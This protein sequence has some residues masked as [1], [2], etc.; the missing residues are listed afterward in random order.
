MR[1]AIK[2]F[3]SIILIVST[4]VYSDDST[5]FYTEKN[6]EG[7]NTCLYSGQKID[8]YAEFKKSL[9][10]ESDPKI[11]DNDSVQSIMIPSGMMAKIYKNDNFSPP[12]FTLIESANV[13][14]LKRLGINREISSIKVSENKNLNC[15]RV[16]TI[17]SAHKINLSDAFG[18]Y[19]HD[20]RLVNRQIILILN[21]KYSLKIEGYSINLSKGPSINV[22]ENEIIFSD[23]NELNQFN[24]EYKKNANELAFIIQLSDDFVQYQYIQTEKKQLVDISP[25][26]SFKWLKEKQINPELTIENYN[27]YNIPVIINRAILTAD[28]GRKNSEKRDLSQ[29][30]K[31]IC[32]FTPFLNIYNYIT[33]GTCQQ[34]DGIIFNALDYFSNNTK[35]KTLHIAG[36]SRPLK[37]IT[38]SKI[39][40]NN[41]SDG[42]YENYLMLSYIDSTNHHQSLSLPAVAKT[43][44]TSIYRLI[45]SRPNRQGRPPC[46]D[47]TLDI[48]TDFTLLFGNDLSTW[49]SEYFS[50]IID[51]IIKTGS[52]GAVVEDAELEQRFSNAVR[53]KV[54]DR[55][56]GNSLGQIK[57]AFDYAQLSYLAHTAYY[58][59]DDM[60]S[61]VEQLPLGIYELLLETFVYRPTIPMIMEHGEQVPQ[62]D[63]N[64]EIEII[65]T[66]TP[67]EA[68]KLS[69]EEIEKIRASRAE[70]AE[71]IVQWGEQYQGSHVVDLDANPDLAAGISK[72]LHAGH[73]VTGI[74]HRR[75]IIKRP[76]EIYVVVKFRG[77]TIAIVLADRFNNRNQVELV[78]SATLPDFVLVP[79]REGAVRGA[80]TAAVIALAQYLKEQGAITLFS[81]VISKPSARVKQKVGFNFKSGF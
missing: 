77:K 10:S 21:S 26:I 48:M 2:L 59:S 74:I 43:C 53:E 34:L 61:Q 20:G 19:W 8:L 80:G 71:T 29:T 64:F 31:A 22:T 73:I 24:F 76:G 1:I 41:T 67:E 28:T 27:Y 70:L 33:H 63:S 57:T 18:R 68:E 5:C 3:A 30:S 32:S 79:N 78:A 12:F 42:V 9:H 56:K 17:L 11:I 50:K 69:A 65:A 44:E 6:F 39:A 62:H 75:L 36:E 15:N 25:I 45:S 13:N 4:S 47:W 7:E 40:N 35:E 81:E 72:T 37:P 23:Y 46:I 38:I 54:V 55:S 14:Q 60:P 52:T 49:N 51:S 58:A 16:C 66:P